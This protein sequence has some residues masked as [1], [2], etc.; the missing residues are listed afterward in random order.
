MSLTPEMREM[1]MNLAATLAAE[2]IAKSLGCSQTVALE[3]LLSSDIGEA[4][5][6]DELKYW[7]ESPSDI[8]D[9][10]LRGSKGLSG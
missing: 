9:A 4:L 3:K 8:A 1:A 2:D 6:D 10:F 5:Y 7:W